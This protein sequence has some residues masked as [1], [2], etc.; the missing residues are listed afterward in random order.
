MKKVIPILCFLVWAMFATQGFSDGYYDPNYHEYQ[1][2]H[3]QLDYSVPSF[4]FQPLPL[5]PV[6]HHS[7]VI[8]PSKDCKKVDIGG[9]YDQKGVY[10]PHYEKKCR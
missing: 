6:P 5:P 9:R 7:R 8:A 3:R 2:P 4:T 10:H 1:Y